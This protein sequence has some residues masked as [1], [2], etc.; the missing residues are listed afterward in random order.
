MMIKNLKLN[1]A[2]LI[3][4]EIFKDRRGFF[5][6]NFNNKKFKKITKGQKFIQGN[7]SFSKKNVL[8][9]IHFQFKNPQYQLFYPIIG[10]LDIFLVDFRP[11]SKTFL[12]S[13]FINL[14]S[15]NNN[16]I[17]TS[18]G[19]GTAFHAKSI[20]NIVIYFVSEFYN[21]KNEIG[22][23]WNDKRLNLNWKCKKPIVSKK[24]NSNFNID[25]IEF[26]KFRDLNKIII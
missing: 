14:K 18:P 12:K 10:E 5:F 26:D 15:K 8:R 6:E 2:F 7:H 23:M 20:E 17:L 3:K 13:I 21:S 4:P 25:N 19:I 9:G 22:V 24:D 16:Q 11:K 1:G